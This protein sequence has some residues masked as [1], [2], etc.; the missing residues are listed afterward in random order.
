MI[1]ALG[2]LVKPLICAGLFHFMVGPARAVVVDGRFSGRVNSTFVS[3]DGTA[4]T[5]NVPNPGEVEVGDQVTGYFTYDTEGTADQHPADP[6]HAEYLY[7]PAGK[8]SLYIEIK[9]RRWASGTTLLIEVENNRIHRPVGQ[10]IINSKFVIQFIDGGSS[11]PGGQRAG[12]GS[13]AFQIAVIS[14]GAP[15]TP[16]SLLKSDS[17]LTTLSDINIAEANEVAVYVL[18]DYPTYPPGRY[19]FFVTVDP[20]SVR[21]TPRH[22]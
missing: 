11:F 9:G 4:I 7:S 18:S 22:E 21:F 15:T 17:L 19:G 3:R 6:T 10:E 12:E 14:K 5:N 20:S 8:N 13:V 1:A 16:N 2:R